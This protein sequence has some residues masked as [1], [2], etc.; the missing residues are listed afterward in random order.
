MAVT[1][2][3][4]MSMLAQNA[5]AQTRVGLHVTQEELNI[6]KERAASGPYKSTGDVSAN[7]PGDWNR[8]MNNANAF[9]TNPSADRWAGQTTATCAVTWGPEPGRRLGNR[10][11]DA[12]FYYLIT[13]DV[14]YRDT[15]RN[16]LLA[17]A[18]VPGTN[19][20]DST[21]WCPGLGDAN[22]TF[23][24]AN[25][26]TRLIFGYDYIRSGL[27]TADKN[28]LDTWFYNA[29]VFWEKN[30]DIGERTYRFPKRNQGDYS[31]NTGT[32]VNVY[33]RITHYGGWTAHEWHRAWTNRGM[34]QAR[35]FTLAGILTNNT[36]LK[37][38]GKRFVKEWLKYSVFPDNTPSEFDRWESSDPDLGWGYTGLVLGSV[39]T[40]ADSLARTSD[41]ELYNYVTSEGLY[42]TQGGPKSILGVIR[43]YMQ[44][45]D[46]KTA[47]YGTDQASQN[48]TLNYRIDDFNPPNSSAR[49][50]DTF[51]ANGNVFYKDSYVKSVYMRT[52]PNTRAYP[53]SP[54]TGGYAAW[55][56]EWGV[57]PG[58]LF[59]FGDMEEKVGPYSTGTQ[60]PTV[61][62]T[63]TPSIIAPAQSSNLTWS[64]T[65]ASSC[66]ASDGWTG[67]KATSGTQAVTATQTTVYTLSCTGT[68]GIAT[69]SVTVSVSSSG[70]SSGSNLANST[71]LIAHSNNFSTTYDRGPENLWDGD[72]I[73]DEGSTGN[74]GISSFWVEFDFGSLHDLTKARLFGDA[75][76]NWICQTWTIQHKQN[77]SDSY[78]TVFANSPCNGNQ[79]FEQPLNGS[80]ARFVR[81]TIFGNPTIPATQARELQIQGTPIL[82]PNPP[83]SLSITQS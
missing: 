49:N 69:K 2:L 4:G 60:I 72:V 25:W 21:R 83:T 39:L 52:A 18:A 62:L 30:I 59:M 47:R 35:F 79:W 80:K 46:G 27:S 44:H 51:V 73:T 63:A 41:L 36:W 64:T 37:N 82:P 78:A 28:T 74:T 38:Q 12:A 16:E 34:A 11:R 76:G 19:F 55:G 14:R 33:V 17:Q 29:G 77:Q 5:V 70:T 45:I 58:V 7:S 31:V 61:N 54:A 68:G 40:I 15:V 43:L 1:V 6:W 81:V 57:Y 67:T 53:G 13:G 48:G 56:G 9:L 23:D 3:V 71:T 24:Y 50:N 65:N 75:D 10:L 26:L 22:P 20:A 32:S 8:I 42:G 66:S